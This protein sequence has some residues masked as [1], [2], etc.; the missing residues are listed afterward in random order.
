MVVLAVVLPVTLLLIAA[1]TL[2]ALAV[3]GQARRTL[4]S[5]AFIQGVDVGGLKFAEAVAK[6]QEKVEAP[7][8]R[9]LTL[10]VDTFKTQTT[11]WD[12]G[13]RVDVPA[14]VRE[15]MKDRGQG[16]IVSRVSSQLFS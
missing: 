11:P 5:G 3:D 13:Y 16:N 15:A 9:P 8:H 6:V 2:G 7:L 14:A 4:P 1:G 10:T 12:L